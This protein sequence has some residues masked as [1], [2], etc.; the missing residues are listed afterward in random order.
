[1]A[2]DHPA[3]VPSRRVPRTKDATATG[4]A[5]GEMRRIISRS[6][7]TAV[8]LPL[9]ESQVHEVDRRPGP[10]H[11]PHRG[12]DARVEPE[13][14][15]GQV[16]EAPPHEDPADQR[17]SDR[18]PDP[19]AGPSAVASGTRHGRG[20][21][22]ALDLTRQTSRIPFPQ[23][24][25]TFFGAC[26]RIHEV[27]R[28]RG[29]PHEARRRRCTS[30]FAAAATIPAV[31]RIVPI[32]FTVGGKPMRWAPK[33]HKGNVVSCPATKFVITKSSR[34]RTNARRNP[35]RIAGAIN[36]SVTLKNATTGLAKRS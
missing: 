5:N 24:D 33:T 1:M 8:P 21:I 30:R 7:A 36:G 19:H 14:P 6:G 18:P 28:G 22:S 10:Q 13:K 20:S 15:I 25:G 26:E 23:V 31:N 34:E 11:D 4:G 29:H 9:A 27:E 35:A 2:A 17:R 3:S 12:E 32:T 16:T